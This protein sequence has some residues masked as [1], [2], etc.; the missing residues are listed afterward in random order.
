MVDDKFFERSDR[1]ALNSE[2]EWGENKHGYFSFESG[3]FIPKGQK[4][5]PSAWHPKPDV[6]VSWPGSEKKK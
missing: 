2:E 5:D 1:A 4:E 3:T 6:S